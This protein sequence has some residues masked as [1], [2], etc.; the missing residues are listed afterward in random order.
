VVLPA[1]HRGRGA[2]QTG[3]GVIDALRRFTPAFLGTRTVSP[4]VRSTLRLLLLCRTP[5]LGG[6]RYDCD[7]CGTSTVLYNSCGNRCCPQCQGKRRLQWV[8]AQQ[9]L[10]L[11]VP[12]FQV[13]FTLPAELRSI[14]RSFPRQIYDLLFQASQLTLKKLAATQWRATPAILSVLHTWT[15]EMTFHPHVHCV[16][17]GGGLTDDGAWVHADPNFLFAIRPMQRLF[18][19]LFLSQLSKLGLDL[20]R[21]QQQH[22]RNARRRAALKNWVVFVEAPGDR[23]PGHLVKYLARYVYQT[24]ISD[25]RIVAITERDVT[26]RTRGSATLTVPGV[27]FVRR[28]TNHFLPKGFRKVRHY[29]LL[30][31]GARHRLAAARAVLLRGVSASRERPKDRPASTHCCPACGTPLRRL[32]LP[33]AAAIAHARGPP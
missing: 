23:D 12:H 9:E 29:G 8:D 10:L 25:H 33:P 2:G 14:A 26:I 6:H 17:S 30:A 19:G 21:G 18:R 24:A 4:S 28:F 20:D 11:P 13:V 16:V 22:L 15:R 7:S 27:E 1:Q 31:P 5:A 3:P 32:H